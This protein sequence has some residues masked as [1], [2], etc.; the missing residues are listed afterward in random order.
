MVQ[1]F[2][3]EYGETI[4]SV[5]TTNNEV[6]NQDMTFISNKKQVLKLGKNLSLCIEGTTVDRVELEQKL[7]EFMQSSVFYPL[8]IRDFFS[9]K[10]LKWDEFLEITENENVE[11]I[12]EIYMDI[13]ES[14]KKEFKN[15]QKNSINIS[16][17][18]LKIFSNIEY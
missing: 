6:V 4:V 15:L 8:L 11:E 10:I 17:K 18:Y 9:D 1:I 16:N 12:Y 14:L 7:Q 13:V 5:I 2:Q 3:K